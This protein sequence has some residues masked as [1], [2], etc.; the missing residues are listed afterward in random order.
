MEDRVGK[1]KE[2]ERFEKESMCRCGMDGVLGV[3]WMVC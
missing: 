2:K 1:G 3:V